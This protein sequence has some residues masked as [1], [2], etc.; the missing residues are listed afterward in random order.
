[1]NFKKPIQSLS[2]YTAFLPFLGKQENPLANGE[3]GISKSLFNP[4]S[5]ISAR[6]MI[7]EKQK[8][9]QYFYACSQ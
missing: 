1:M 7:I 5:I 3:G 4:I 6:H 8:K 9:N 2:Q